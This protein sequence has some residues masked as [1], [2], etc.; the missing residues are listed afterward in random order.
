[1][2]RATAHL[3]AIP[4]DW[5]PRRALHASGRSL[6]KATAGPGPQMVPEEVPDDD[7]DFEVPL[8][9]DGR[10]RASGVPRGAGSPQSEE[11]QHILRLPEYY[12][13]LGLDESVI[14]LEKIERAFVKR[15]QEAASP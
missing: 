9:A 2:A 8:G 10:P 15:L 13:K 7:E 4:S 5:K 3:D 11:H 1:M 14:D 6:A 12:R